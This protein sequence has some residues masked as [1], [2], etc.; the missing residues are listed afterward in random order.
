MSPPLVSAFESG[1]RPIL[2]PNAHYKVMDEASV[3][4]DV[5]DCWQLA[6]ESG[7]SETGETQIQQ[8]AAK[9]AAALAVFGA[10]A[11]AAL[12]GDPHRAAVAGAVGGGSASIAAGML[13]QEN[14]P[15]VFRAIV[16]RCLF[17]KGYEVAGWE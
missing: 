12:G 17:E 6:R 8:Q 3:R 13:A 15:G 1:K 14:P 9:D 4:T 10:A 7:A 5:E 16:E 2:Y 11:A